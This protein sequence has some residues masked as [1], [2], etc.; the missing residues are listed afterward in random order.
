MCILRSLVRSWLMLMP[1]LVPVCCLQ[2]TGT[3]LETLA[4]SAGKASPGIERSQACR[5]SSATG[6]ASS[7]P[8][9]QA[10]AGLAI[11]HALILVTCQ[12]LGVLTGCR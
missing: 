7:A 8:P 6:M 10:K 4:P 9:A 2:G 3:I 11:Y 5:Q 1:V 12:Q